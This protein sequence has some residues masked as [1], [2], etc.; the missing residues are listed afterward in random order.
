MTQSFREYHVKSGVNHGPISDN[1]VF[2]PN[3]RAEPA[4]ETVRMEIVEGPL[5]TEI[6]QYFYR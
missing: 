5:V 4:W 1:Y 2:I 6:R 3:G